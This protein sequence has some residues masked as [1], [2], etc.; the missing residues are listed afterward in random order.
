V[1]TISR[2]SGLYASLFQIE[3]Q[4]ARQAA[5]VSN[6]AVSHKTEMNVYKVSQSRHE[7]KGEATCTSPASKPSVYT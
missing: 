4:L 7:L 2:R 6:Q 3:A 1:A 5:I